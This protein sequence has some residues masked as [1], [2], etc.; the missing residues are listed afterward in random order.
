MKEDFKHPKDLVSAVLQFLIHDGFKRLD[1]AFIWKEETWRYSAYKV[2]QPVE[3]VR[4]DIRK[5]EN[6]KAI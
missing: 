1:G 3:L 2:S 4:I 5:K 6:E